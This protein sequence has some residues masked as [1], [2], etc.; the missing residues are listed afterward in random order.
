M[1]EFQSDLPARDVD[2]HL[3]A[4]LRELACAERNAVL[5]FA[6]VLR[7]KLYRKL[8]YGSIHQYA[9]LALGFR[10]AKTAQFIRLSEALRELPRLR[11]SLQRGEVGWT[12]ARTVAVVATP[13]TETAWLEVAKGESRTKLEARVRQARAR[14][15][16]AA[17]QAR[18]RGQVALALAPGGVGSS[19]GPEEAVGSG[20]VEMS[21]K[22]TPEQYA[23]YEALLELLRRRGVRDERVEVLLGGLEALA[24]ETAAGKG[25][26]EPK[27]GA[28]SGLHGGEA[29]AG[30]DRGNA[31]SRPAPEGARTE[32]SDN[33]GKTQVAAGRSVP[34]PYQVHVQ[35]C[36]SCA[37][38]SVVTGRGPE[39]L[40][41][42]ELRA[43]LC[44]ARLRW[45]GGR[46]R[47]VIPPGVRRAVLERDGF[48]C[49]A[50]GCGRARFLAVH[51]LE[52]R[53]AG[54]S[55]DPENLI[56]LCG[57]CHRALHGH[58]TP[59]RHRKDRRGGKPRHEYPGKPPRRGEPPPAKLG[60]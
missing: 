11:E 22:F 29:D 35:L 3:R 55:N 20:A 5:W 6:E 49:R 24:A 7:R 30:V 43:I 52:P 21:L 1:S 58:D 47:A 9:E 57:A 50:A 27:N 2:R 23:R 51:H 25:R 38:G 26:K 12:K 15:R 13:K 4:S 45:R 56:T 10:P 28:D 59:S 48:R 36:P 54:G 42:R 46:N 60:A 39:A 16:A 18:T 17:K 8:G 53:E 19:R 34:P 44:D 33:G 37:G 32:G 31:G 41:P 14:T 40:H